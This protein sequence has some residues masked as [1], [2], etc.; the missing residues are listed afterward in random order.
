MMAKYTD[1]LFINPLQIVH[2]FL[3]KLDHQ[4]VRIVYLLSFTANR[5]HA[6]S[7]NAHLVRQS[8]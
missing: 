5:V 6:Q 4:I 8:W 7:E 3:E 2:E 1:Q